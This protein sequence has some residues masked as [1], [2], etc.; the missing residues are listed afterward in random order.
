[1]GSRSHLQ[2]VGSSVALLGRRNLAS[3]FEAQAQRNADVRFAIYIRSLGGGR[4]SVHNEC[5]DQPYTVGSIAANLTFSKDQKVTLGSNYGNVGEVILGVAPPNLAGG[6]AIVNLSL[7]SA[8]YR[9]RVAVSLGDTM[10]TLTPNPALNNFSATLHDPGTGA[11]L[12]VRATG[13]DSPGPYTGG[14]AYGVIGCISQDVAGRCAPGSFIFARQGFGERHKL[15]DVD[16]HHLRTVPFSFSLQVQSA[17]VYS[18]GFLW[19]ARC[20]GF[21][22]AA[23]PVSI[24]LWRCRCDCSEAEQVGTASFAH[25]GGAARLQLFGAYPGQVAL[26]SE[27]LTWTIP[28]ADRDDLSH[29]GMATIRMARAGGP[30][31]GASLSP[32]S[33]ASAGSPVYGVPLGVGRSLLAYGGSLVTLA[34]RSDDPSSDYASAWPTSGVFVLPSVTSASLSRGTPLVAAIYGI[35]G[36]SHGKIVA[37]SPTSPSSASVVTLEDTPLGPPAWAFLAI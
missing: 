35:G 24:E 7:V 32:V 20:A 8:P 31:S 13:G 25:F 12:S 36:D 26:S 14:G 33:P 6:E 19:F 23:D 2:G 1:M 34:A 11:F 30:A 37:A 17:P 4:H 28:W 29:A 27:F 15:W 16:G 21:L 10:Y 18:D 22:E 5:N 9:I 3:L